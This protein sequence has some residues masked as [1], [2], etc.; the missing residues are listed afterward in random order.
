MDPYNYLYYMTMIKQGPQK[1][2]GMATAMGEAASAGLSDNLKGAVE[3]FNPYDIRGSAQRLINATGIPEVYTNGIDR[4][5][6]AA[7]DN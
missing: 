5:L 4:N 7:L 1:V 6:Q 2:R 3:D